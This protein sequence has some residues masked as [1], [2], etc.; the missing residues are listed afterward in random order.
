MALPRLLVRVE[1][2]KRNSHR[3]VDWTGSADVENAIKNDIDDYMFDVVR[4]EHSVP[5]SPEAIEHSGRSIPH[6]RSAAGCMMVRTTSYGSAVIEYGLERST[7]RTLS[8]LLGTAQIEL[9]HP[10][11]SATPLV[12]QPAFRLSGDGI[13]VQKPHI[14]TSLVC[15]CGPG[16]P[17][18]RSA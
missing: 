16:I 5:I 15:V 18:T 13:T 6:G 11:L 7:R 1:G 14:S 17:S 3:R 2:P 9:D 4:G 10:L 12:D 8:A